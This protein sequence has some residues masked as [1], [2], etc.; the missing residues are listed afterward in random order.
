L[1]IEEDSG[2]NT[3]GAIMWWGLQ[4]RNAETVQQMSRSE[5]EAESLQVVQFCRKHNK[6]TLLRSW[7]NRTECCQT[8]AVDSGER[9]RSVNRGKLGKSLIMRLVF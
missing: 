2:A 4:A 5:V 7:S 9:L 3:E 6:T 8:D 1:A